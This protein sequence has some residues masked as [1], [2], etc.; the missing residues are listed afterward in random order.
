MTFRRPLRHLTVAAAAVV[1]VVACVACNDSTGSSTA[2]A[3]PLDQQVWNASLGVDVSK[4]TR[5]TSGVYFLDSIAGTGA[6]LTGTPTVSVF[7]AGYLPNG[8]KFDEAATTPACFPLNGL[9]GGWQ[10]GLQGMKIG[11]TRRL[12]IPPALG[13]GASGNGPVP[14]NANLLFDVQLNATG[15]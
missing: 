11:G 3:I 9:I 2:A 12:L 4:F 6:T 13:Y 10:V 8:T 14:G 7:Y 1:A 15:C 5:L